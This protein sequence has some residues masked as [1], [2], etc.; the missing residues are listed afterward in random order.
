MI[1]NPLDSVQ[2]LGFSEWYL[3]VGAGKLWAAQD[4]D[5][6]VPILSFWPRMNH[7]PLA[8]ANRGAE[9]LVGSNYK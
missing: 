5:R 2:T 3:K 6:K 7:S 4:S 8:T 9:L 1:C